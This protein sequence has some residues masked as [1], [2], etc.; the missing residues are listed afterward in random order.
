MSLVFSAF[1][2]M[3]V[4]SYIYS[5]KSAGMMA[6]LPIR[7]EAA[8]LTVFSAGLCCLLAS[9]VLVFLI[10]MAVE[11]A[12]GVLSIKFLLQWLALVSMCNVFFYGFASLCAMLTDKYWCFPLYTQF[13]FHPSSC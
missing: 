13:K 11:A 4:F 1:T 10:A 5:S 8:F 9:N 6:S 12:H 2:A 7:R 3:A